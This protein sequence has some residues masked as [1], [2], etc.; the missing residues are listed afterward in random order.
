MGQDM[1]TLLTYLTDTQTGTDS[2]RVG[3]HCFWKRMVTNHSGT[4]FLPESIIG[5]LLLILQ[6]NGG[7]K[8]ARQ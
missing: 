2:I 6:I 7:T 4:K 3:A 5:S 1:N 8:E